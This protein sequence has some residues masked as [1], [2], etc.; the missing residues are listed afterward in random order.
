MTKHEGYFKCLKIITFKICGLIKNLDYLAFCQI[1]I[2][3]QVALVVKNSPVNEGDVRDVDSVPGSGNS[4]EGGHTYIHIHFFFHPSFWFLTSSEMCVKPLKYNLH[5]SMLRLSKYT[6]LLHLLKF[7][8][9]H[10]YLFLERMSLPPKKKPVLIGSPS[11]LS[12]WQILIHLFL[13]ICLSQSFYI[14][15][16]I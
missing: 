5:I 11:L 15:G 7:C 14:C 3:S 9:L 10:H 16:I 12:P 6:I 8:K 1:Y 13:W 4:P 2:A